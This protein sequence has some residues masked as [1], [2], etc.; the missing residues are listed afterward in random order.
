MNSNSIYVII[1]FMK[2]N[3]CP[4]KCNID[5]K[6]H[7]GFCSSGEELRVA[8][9]GL[10][11]WEEPC[12]SGQA[13]SGTI[14]FTGC[15]LKCIFCQ[16][17]E[18]SGGGAGH[19]V[20]PERLAEV[21]IELQNKKAN[22][23]NLVTAGHFLD[24]VCDTIILARKNGLNIPI[25]YNTSSYE[26]VEAIQKLEGLVD[27]YLPDFKYYDDNLAL[28]YSKAGGYRDIAT[29]AIDEMV[30][31]CGHAE[32]NAE[33]IMTRGVIVRHLVLP[34]HTKDSM[35]ILGYLHERY[36][37]KIS[38]SIMNQYTPVRECAE[39][40]NLNRKVTPRE[41]DKVCNYA[42]EIGIENGFFQEGDVA[43]QSFIPEFDFN[44]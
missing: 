3:I 12:I 11:M 13:G 1:R 28:K 40:T 14:F 41:Y 42:I 37:D 23:I 35:K 2:C 19:T 7:E 32:Y 43:L 24:K 10:H 25:V 38:I 15:N 36:G 18:I 30:L 17:H 34:Q 20:S 22:N 9:A 33:G 21:M 39:Y 29:G 31:Q 6:L 4:R 5:R 16:N 8:R 27:V 44:G 26:S